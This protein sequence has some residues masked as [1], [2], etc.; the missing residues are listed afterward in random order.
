MDDKI[1]GNRGSPTGSGDSLSLWVSASDNGPAVR[2][3]PEFLR[4]LA[5][6]ALVR[7]GPR[8]RGAARRQDQDPL[9]AVLTRTL[10]Q[11]VMGQTCAVYRR[12]MFEED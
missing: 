5:N 8:T 6:L 11:N 7:E 3:T 4:T 1:R 12:V 10:S 2:R 9:T